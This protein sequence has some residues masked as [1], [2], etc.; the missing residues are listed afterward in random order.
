MAVPD[1]IVLNGCYITVKKVK[2]MYRDYNRYGEYSCFDMS[3]NI[4]EDMSDQKQE[5]IFVHE[6]IEAIKDIYLMDDLK[7]EMIQPLAV[8]IYE[9]IKKRQL[10]FDDTEVEAVAIDD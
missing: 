7:H 2:N 5:V 3:I 6:V 10:T 4:D 9:L 8:A 1:S